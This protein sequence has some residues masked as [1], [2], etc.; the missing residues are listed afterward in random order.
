MVDG[1]ILGWLQE[2]EWVCPL[3]PKFGGTGLLAPRIG[4][5]GRILWVDQQSRSIE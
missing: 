1:A 2:V 5:W 3:A 4:G